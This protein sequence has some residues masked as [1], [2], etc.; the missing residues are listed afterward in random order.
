ML[1]CFL[2]YIESYSHHVRVCFT[3]CLCLLPH[4]F[5][6]S[7]VFIWLASS[8]FSPCSV[9]LAVVRSSVLGS[10]KMQ[11][12]PSNNGLLNPLTPKPAPESASDQPARHL[13][14]SAPEPACHQPVPALKLGSSQPSR[15]QMM[16]TILLSFSL[17]LKIFWEPVLLCP[18]CSL[19]RLDWIG[20]NCNLSVHSMSI[21]Y[22]I[23]NCANQ[24]SFKNSFTQPTLLLRGIYV[25]VC[26]LNCLIKPLYTVLFSM[27]K[28]LLFF[29]NPS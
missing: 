8:V 3:L 14:A 13:P 6:V 15:Y 19:L 29:A 5:S 25:S 23:S 7:P 24:A 10:F 26:L 27:F 20:L 11:S 9:P 22:S 4:L 2:F 16:M 1:L 12:Q 28:I 18:P 21:W 17:W